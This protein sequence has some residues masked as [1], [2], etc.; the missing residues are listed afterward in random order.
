[1]NLSKAV[2]AS[3]FIGLLGACAPINFPLQIQNVTHQ[4]QLMV[5]QAGAE[6][7]VNTRPDPGCRRSN[8]VD[9]CIHV[10]YNEIAAVEFRLVTG[11]GWHLTQFQI[12]KGSDKA[13]QD[14]NLNV[15]E[16]ME[17]AATDQ[18]FTNIVFPDS[19][20]IIDLTAVGANLDKFVIL[21]QNNFE[22]EWYY[23]VT[24]CDTLNNTCPDT[25]PPWEND[26]RN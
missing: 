10:G 23:T 21:D 1:M 17:W 5:I 16:R 22:Q 26:G 14:C 19:N 15:W 11:G 18:N 7:K 20:G 25:D 4:V 6:L 8:Q 13:G 3:G 12:C 9:G 2:L 24:A